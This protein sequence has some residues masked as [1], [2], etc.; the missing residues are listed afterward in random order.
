MR[1]FQ[2]TFDASLAY[3]S[4]SITPPT[5]WFTLWRVIVS[6]TSYVDMYPG[7]MHNQFYVEG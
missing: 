4:T 2:A 1:V 3:Q 5:S 6:D 7:Q